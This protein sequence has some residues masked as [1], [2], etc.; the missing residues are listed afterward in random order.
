MMLH[1]S[2]IAHPHP[3]AVG[4]AD[5][6]AAHAHR[7]QLLGHQKESQRKMQLNPHSP[8]RCAVAAATR[9]LLKKTLLQRLGVENVS[10]LRQ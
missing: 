2:Q 3:A 7:T 5:D 1:W 6:R 4:V 9:I 10:W 8:L